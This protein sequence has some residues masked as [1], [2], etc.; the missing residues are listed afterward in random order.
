VLSTDG[1]VVIGSGE[2]IKPDHMLA[3]A[4]Y[5]NVDPITEPHLLWI[6]RQALDT[7]IP[8]DWEAYYDAE[9]GHVCYRSV[10]ENRET[11]LLK[12][13]ADH[14]FKGLIGRERACTVAGAAAIDGAWM[15]FFSDEGNSYYFSFSSNTISNSKPKNATI[16]VKPHH[17]AAFS[18]GSDEGI[19][20]ESSSATLS[21][22]SSPKYIEAIR[23]LTFK[24]W[25]NE[26]DQRR[27]VE[28]SFHMDTGNF[29][30]LFDKS[31]KMYTLSHIDGFNGPLQCWDLYVGAVVNVL[32][33]S[34]TLQQADGE[35][36]EWLEF[37]KKRLQSLYTQ[38]VQAH[39]T[40]FSDVSGCRGMLCPSS[41]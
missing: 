3:M 8:P 21:E 16:L 1:R 40:G 35:T 17:I 19:K 36:V 14:Y 37:H 39:G 11:R 13:P 26:D 41:G 30:V 12:H 23:V 4:A 25:W 38:M 28:I 33:R 9:E 31:D 5:Y 34:T 2:N 10:L 29:Q 6:V 24:S 20:K 15:E 32:G 18:M 27:C 22:G 7:P